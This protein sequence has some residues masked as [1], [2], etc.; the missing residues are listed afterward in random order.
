M[1]PLSKEENVKERYSNPRFGFVLGA[2]VVIGI[3]GTLVMKRVDARYFRRI[4]NSDWITPD[5][6]GKERWLKGVV[7][8]SV[9]LFFF[10]F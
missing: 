1:P 8:E 10:V 6:L 3:V 5:I 2:G 7:T 4:P 9:D